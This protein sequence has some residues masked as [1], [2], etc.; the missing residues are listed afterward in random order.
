VLFMSG[1]DDRETAADGD[2]AAFLPK[3][4][5]PDSLARKVREVLDR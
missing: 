1:H 4:F 2:R 5:S 3:P